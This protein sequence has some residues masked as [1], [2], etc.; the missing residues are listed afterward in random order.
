MDLLVRLAV[1]DLL[2]RLAVVDLL[3]ARLASKPK[4]EHASAGQWDRT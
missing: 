3:D 4:A 2:V 1:V